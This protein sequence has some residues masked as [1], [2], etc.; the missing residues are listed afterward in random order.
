MKKKKTGLPRLQFNKEAISILNTWHSAGVKGGS[1]LDCGGVQVSNGQ[2]I[3]CIGHTCESW[4]S[5]MP[6]CWNCAEA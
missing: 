6:T 4:N 2:P 1:G 3:S 5:E